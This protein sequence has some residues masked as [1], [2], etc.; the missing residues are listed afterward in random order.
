MHQNMKKLGIVGGVAWPSTVDYYR[1]ICRLSVEHHRGLN[2][3]GPSPTPEMSIESLNL[4]KSYGLRGGDISDD[5]SWARYDAYFR[6]ALLRLEKSGAQ[7]AIIA[8]NTPHNRFDAITD[9][10]TIPVLN[11]FHAVAEHCQSLGL[12]E[13][14]ILGTAP[15]MDSPK[16]A[17]ALRQFGIEGWAPSEQA[18]RS[19]VVK[20]IGELQA[21]SDNDAQRRIAEVVARS[22]FSGAHTPTACLACTELPLAFKEI[23]RSTEVLVN[24]VLY[25]NTTVV[26]AKAAFRQLLVS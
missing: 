15:T 19:E 25:V 22:T 9:G 4:D 21:E 18:D 5:R 23:E 1:A 12:K 3:S 17:E 10:I 13:L 8:S 20:L 16:F 26:H 6:D 14:L 7:I 2:V 11:I 24:G